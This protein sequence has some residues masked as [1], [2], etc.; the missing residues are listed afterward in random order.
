MPNVAISNIFDNGQSLGEPQ[1]IKSTFNTYFVNDAT[2][3]Q[4]FIRYSK[5]I[6]MNLSLQ[7]IFF[8]SAVEVEVKNIII[9]LNPSKIVGLN[10][11]PTKI[12]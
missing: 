9:F 10:S 4:S 5:I 3:I 8:Q 6:C 12:Y 2:D 1:V 11:I 7:L